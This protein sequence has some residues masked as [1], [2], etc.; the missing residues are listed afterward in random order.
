MEVTFS[1]TINDV[2]LHL[3]VFVHPYHAPNHSYY[4]NHLPYGNARE[5]PVLIDISPAGPNTFPFI[6]PKL[7]CNFRL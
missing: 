6:I 2:K 5:L 7:S 3:Y 1:L 4:E